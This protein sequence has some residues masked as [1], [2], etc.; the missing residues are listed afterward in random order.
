LRRAAGLAGV[1][2]LLA[3]PGSRAF[4]RAA[5]EL[6]ADRGAAGTWQKLRKLR[7]TASAMHTTAHPDDE[8]GGLLARLGRGQGA[9]VALLTLNRGESGDNAIGPELFDGLGLVRTEELRVADRYYGVDDQYFTPFV[10]Y[11]F[12]KRLDEALE[13]WGRED[14][15]R[16]VVRVVRIDRP[17]V[18]IARFQG[19]SRDGHGQHQA[20]GLVT[21]EAFRAAGDPAMFPEHAAEGLRPWQPLKLY[22][23]GVSESE[24]WTVRTDAGEYSPWLGESYGNF[25]RIGLSF[26]RSQNGGLLNLTP[27]SSYRYF[28]RLA[29]TVT[30]PEKETSFFDEIDTRLPGLFSMLKRP[31]PA[32]AAEALRDI[33]RS[34][35][36]AAGAFTVADPSAC[37]PALA[38][39]LEATRAAL[40]LVASEPDAAFLL[41]IKEA[42]F[43]DAINAALGL[44]LTAIAQPTDA[45]EPTGPFAAFAP[46]TTLAAPVPGQSFEVVTRLANRGGIE[47]AP[48]EVVI[49]AGRGW[50]V[51]PAPGALPP[52]L[53]RNAV[54]TRRLGITL[55]EDVPLTSRPHF[56]RPSISVNRYDVADA[57]ERSRPVPAPAAVAV[58]RYDVAGVAVEAREALRRRE[59]LL[60]YGYALREVRVVPALA[61]NLSPSRAVI[62]VGGA[63]RS[64]GLQVELIGNADGALA[65][66]VTLELPP[67]WTA[68]PTSRPF[69]FARPGERSAHTFQVSVPALAGRAYEVQAV[70]TAAGRQYREGYQI[71]AHRDLE[72]RYLYRAARSEVRGVDVKVAPGLSVGYVMGVG[73]QVPAGIAQLGAK[74]QL[75]GDKELANGDL[76]RFDAIVT[77]TRAYVVREDLNTYNQRLLDYVKGGGNL[78][79]LYNTPEFVPAKLAP[80]PAELPRNAEEVSEEDSPVEILAPGHPVLRRPNAITLADFDGWVEQRGS[81]FFASWDPAYTAL[82]ATRDEGQEPQ[83]GG[84]VT[85]RYGKGH[86]TYFAYALHR[87]LPYGVPGAYRL[88]ANLLSLGRAAPA[89]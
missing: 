11:G 31:A 21:Q 37:V 54:A 17:L 1:C 64:L 33:E 6:P 83:Q 39:G 35:D 43:M 63:R 65:G 68:S 70:A 27:G 66:T 75:L 34:V 73:D 2:A 38:R 19:N 28:R 5:N 20:A 61:V 49:E 51:V 9:R 57:A 47:I 67:G 25:A 62:P 41:R 53:G 60:P 86:Y 72:T 4:G 23:G 79:V 10:D 7:T 84:W 88:L 26:Q 52:V 12:S 55:A 15:L 80:F 22:V 3:G 42:Q 16:E 45:P 48:S 13:K 32:G 71:V 24:D 44:E 18:L 85:A 50:T 81:K 78:I 82:I 59:A 58:A 77:G 40:T 8:N 46:P 36:D 74:V 14:L 87:Q 76:G 30:A 69:R 29:S 89:P 56:S